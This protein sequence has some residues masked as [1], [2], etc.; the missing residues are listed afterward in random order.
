MDE[1]IKKS[2]FDY[3][4]HCIKN[5]RYHQIDQKVDDTKDTINL[6]AIRKSICPDEKRQGQTQKEHHLIY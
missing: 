2:T 6:N 5:D 3:I 1:F 4:M